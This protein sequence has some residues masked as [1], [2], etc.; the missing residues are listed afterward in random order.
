MQIINKEEY[1][2]NGCTYEKITYNNGYMDIHI[3]PEPF[4]SSPEPRPEPVTN[5][6]I[7]AA[8]NKGSVQRGHVEVAGTSVIIQLEP[9][10]VSRATVSISGPVRSYTLTEDQLT[11]ELTEHGY[12]NWEVRG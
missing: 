9:V 11:M 3:K 7:L 10:D 8:M 6:D 4:E 2:D 12:I 1:Q 5:E